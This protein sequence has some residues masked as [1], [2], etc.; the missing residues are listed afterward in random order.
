MP[1]LSF[2][3]E[4]VQNTKSIILNS[5][6]EIPPDAMILS[7]KATTN[8]LDKQG[9]KIT[10][11]PKAI[12]QAFEDFI[13]NGGKV[14]IEHGRIPKFGDKQVG[15]V[16][17]FILPKDYKEN[18][19]SGNPPLDIGVICAVTDTETKAMIEN[20]E[21]DSF[22]LGWDD[23]IRTQNRETGEFTDSKIVIHELSLTGTPANPEATFT[24][25]DDEYIKNKYL[26]RGQKVL[27]KSEPAQIKEVYKNQKGLY[28]FDILS[29]R[30]EKSLS[31]IDKEE[32]KPIINIKLPK[33]K[34][35]CIKDKKICLSC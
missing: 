25:I 20:G 35:A 24:I 15:V 22:S 13:S 26:K 8:A 18:V 19:E 10:I 29:G 6:Q 12:K 31:K 11:L 34:K 9:E 30:N 14:L 7:G 27:Y 28:C 32:I 23:I 17:N 3:F 4:Q 16:L 5:S 33:I 21:L 1:E 2:K